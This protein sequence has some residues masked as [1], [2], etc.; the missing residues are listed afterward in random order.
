V[1]T[2]D[3]RPTETFR[4]GDTE[5]V[6][7]DFRR[8]EGLTRPQ[9]ELVDAALGRFAEM[10]D[11][12]LTILMRR[13]TTLDLEGV[14]ESTWGDLLTSRDDH[15]VPVPFHLEPLEGTCV[16]VLP[17]A[18]SRIVADL[19][20][21]G[22][23]ADGSTE[24]LGA[25]E[26]GLVAQFVHSVLARMHASFVELMDVSAQPAATEPD[27]APLA[28]LDPDDLC[29]VARFVLTLEERP[30]V[31]VDICLPPPTVRGMME[32][33]RARL[34][35]L[36][37]G[38]RRPPTTQATERLAHVPLE[39]TLQFPTIATTAESLLQLAVG[40]EL[41]LGIPTSEPLEVRAEGLLVA[42]AT[43]GRSGDRKAC[44]IVEE[45]LP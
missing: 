44:S 1:T 41:A 12:E 21:G 23:G 40:D 16:V 42:R 13:P 36:E 29:L 33:L 28:V 7:H 9:R 45:V 34:A 32:S 31:A 10:A 5:V 43:I 20:L 37:S 8:P 19:R 2:T 3:V 17:T 27:A 4:T 15:P 6:L 35:L 11:D 25:I 14:S 24:P 39:V 30:P 38:R 18:T 22:A 26:G